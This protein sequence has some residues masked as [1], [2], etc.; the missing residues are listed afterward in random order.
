MTSSLTELTF[1]WFLFWIPPP[2]WLPN[3]SCMLCSC[4]GHPGRPCL[5]ITGLFSIFAG[6]APCVWT[7][8]GGL[9]QGRCW[10]MWNRAE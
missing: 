5:W 3:L 4:L 7:K 8:P 2:P 6:P 10:A 9:A 1:F